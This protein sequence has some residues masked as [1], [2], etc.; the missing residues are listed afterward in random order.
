MRHSFLAWTLAMIIPFGTCLSAQ[1]TAKPEAPRF[2]FFTIGLLIEK[3]TTANK[4]W[5]ELQGKEKALNERLKVKE[6]E[7]V[8]I[9]KQSQAASIDAQGR[10]KLK[11]QQQ[12]LEIEFKRLQEDS[13]LEYGRIR[14]KVEGDILKLIEP[15]VKKL[16]EEQ[17]LQAVI[18]GESAGATQ[19]LIWADADWFNA[20][21]LEVAKRLDGSKG[22]AAGTVVPPPAKPASP[23][24]PANPVIKKP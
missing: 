1:T 7:I 2:A 3:S 22:A 17:Q 11:K 5:S 24:K 23:A 8:N 13:Q 4:I 19:L 15:I 20:F 12:S 6:N 10:E 21:T 18:S 14:Q 16:A 9:Q